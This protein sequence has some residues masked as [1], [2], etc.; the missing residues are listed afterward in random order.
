MNIIQNNDQISYGKVLTES[1]CW[2]FNFHV[3]FSV[4]IEDGVETQIRVKGQR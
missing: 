4:S 3:V 2:Q 1:L